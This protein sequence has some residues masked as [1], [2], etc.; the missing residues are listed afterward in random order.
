MKIIIAEDTEDSRIMLEMALEAEGYEV[1]SGENGQKA[2]DL[3]R[4]SRPDLIISDIMMPEMDGFEFC[5]QVKKDPELNSVPFIFYTATYTD[6]RDRELAFAIGASRFLIKPQEP[7]KLMEIIEETIALSREKYIQTQKRPLEDELAIEEMHLHSVSKKL[8]KKIH[9]L[10]R[11]HDA[12]VQSEDRYRKLVEALQDYYFFYTRQ[13]D[14]S[15]CYVSPSVELILGYKP[16]EF[17]SHYTDLLTSNPINKQARLFSDLSEKGEE[18]KPYSIEIYHK[19]GSKHYLEIKEV[20]A[21]DKQ[22]RVTHIEG[23]V[24]DIT[25]QKRAEDV[26]R[27]SQKMAALGKLTGGIAHDYNNVLGVVLGYAELLGTLVRDQPELAK[28]VNAIGRAA[29]RGNKLSA[30]LLGF[31][32]LKVADPELVD[33]NKLLIESKDMLQ[34]SFTARIK[35]KLDLAG[36]LWRADLDSSDFEDAILNLC[37]NSMHAIDGNGV[38]SIQ[39]RNEH[40]DDKQSRLLEL[41]PGDYI[42]VS[43]SDTGCGIEKSIKELIFDPFFSTKGDKG[44][45]LGLSQVYGFVE[46]S[47]GGVKVYS[48]PGNGACFNLYFPR[49]LSDDNQAGEVPEKSLAELKG[50]ETILVVDDEPALLDITKEILTQNGY[51]FYC[52]QSAEEALSLLENTAVDLMV[53]DIIMPEMDGYELKKIVHKKYPQVKVIYTSGFSQYT[54]GGDED[55]EILIHKPYNSVTLL[56]KIR[57]ALD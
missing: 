46:R 50:N 57:Q 45:G 36:D 30:K 29:E 19:D 32:R 52:A 17:C 8:D 25:E 37:I 49:S 41:P 1:M 43:I 54:H 21:F 5:R 7:R 20:P 28:Y 3:A 13:P 51:N 27:R 40:V 2:L 26:I 56:R 55:Q 4:A 22:N 11:E 39:T 16:D 9:E 24:H 48:E 42:Q 34:K 31:S 38:I 53:T 44:T 10:D 12:L 15:L 6:D 18:Q 47:K 33:I 35:L 23:I 14:G